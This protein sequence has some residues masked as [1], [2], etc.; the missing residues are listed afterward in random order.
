METFPLAP[1]SPRPM[2]TGTTIQH[3][4]SSLRWVRYSLSVDDNV[5]LASSHYPMGM[6]K[7]A[8]T[9]ETWPCVCHAGIN[10]LSPQRAVSTAE[11]EPSR[12]TGLLQ[13][14]VTPHC[15]FLS[16]LEENWRW[17]LDSQRH[18]RSHNSPSLS[19]TA[20]LGQLNKYLK[21]F[22]P[23]TWVSSRDAAVSSKNVVFLNKLDRL[24]WRC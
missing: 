8:N 18:M 2:G 1:A 23:G 20:E 17:T 6:R 21:R 3:F 22:L 9:L 4:I 13:C 15:F 12:A 5:W 14:S 7:C 19:I 16:L 10:H 24:W 11:N